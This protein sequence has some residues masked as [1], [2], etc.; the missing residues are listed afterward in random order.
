MLQ[1]TLVKSLRLVLLGYH[2]RR[3]ERSEHCCLDYSYTEHHTGVRN[4]AMEEIT[5]WDT[6]C[7]KLVILTL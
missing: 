4:F 1:R 2:G 5:V 6:V 7:F 3:N